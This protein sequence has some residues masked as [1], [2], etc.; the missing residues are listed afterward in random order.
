M[1]FFYR[2]YFV[3]LCWSW[4]I[5]CPTPSPTHSHHSLHQH[6]RQRGTSVGQLLPPNSINFKHK[7]LF[8]PERLVEGIICAI[9]TNWSAFPPICRGVAWCAPFI[10]NIIKAG[11]FDVCVTCSHWICFCQTSPPPVLLST[12]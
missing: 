3:R 9:C 6:L 10:I 12:N 8:H 4:F 7:R 2:I 5:S 1:V 11:V